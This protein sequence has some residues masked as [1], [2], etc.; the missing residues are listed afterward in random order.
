[1]PQAKEQARPGPASPSRDADAARGDG[2]AR[3][4][5]TTA[6]GVPAATPPQP[7]APAS[8]GTAEREATRAPARQDTAALRPE[9]EPAAPRTPESAPAV[10]T[11]QKPPEPPPLHDPHALARRAIDRELQGDRAGAI[12]DVRAALS[13]ETDPAHRASLEQFLRLLE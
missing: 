11:E 10:T 12:A 7:R 9:P 2:A 8:S 4:S 3:G 5:T 6:T 13:L 1:M